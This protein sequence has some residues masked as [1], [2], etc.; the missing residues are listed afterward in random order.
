[1]KE[2]SFESNKQIETVD[3]FKE[4]VNDAINNFQALRLS[5]KA[6][7][8]EEAIQDI[9]NEQTF[10]HLEEYL[11]KKGYVLSAEIKESQQEIIRKYDSFIDTLLAATTI[12]ELR[13]IN[14]EALEYLKAAVK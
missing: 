5:L 14:Q 11:E 4:R 12:E 7:S 8:Y 3:A 1:M 10:V 9:R 13:E 6:N 2:N